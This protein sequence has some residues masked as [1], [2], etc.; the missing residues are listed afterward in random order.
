MHITK[1]VGGKKMKRKNE[2]EMIVPHKEL[3]IGIVSWFIIGLIVGVVVF[4]NSE[5][6]GCHGVGGFVYQEIEWAD[7]TYNVMNEN[8]RGD[9]G[10]LKPLYVKDGQLQCGTFVFPVT[11]IGG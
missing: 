8:C 3:V 1:S 6:C 11:N 4:A 7:Q 10:E 2:N 9:D 5:Q